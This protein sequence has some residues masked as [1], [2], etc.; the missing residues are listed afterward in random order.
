MYVSNDLRTDQA[1]LQWTRSEMR[2]VV[3]KVSYE[4]KKYRRSLKP[5]P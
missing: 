2:Y 5:V 3:I 1:E 4:V